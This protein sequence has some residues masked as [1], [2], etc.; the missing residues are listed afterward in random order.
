MKPIYSKPPV[1]KEY[2]ENGVKVTRYE[3]RKPKATP[4][5]RVYRKPTYG[6]K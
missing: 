1:V 6:S 5:P 3:M 2:K 4:M